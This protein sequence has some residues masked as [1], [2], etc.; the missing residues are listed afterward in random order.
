VTII[1]DLDTGH[2]SG[3]CSKGWPYALRV[4]LLC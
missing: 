4:S 1:A 3:A 2:A